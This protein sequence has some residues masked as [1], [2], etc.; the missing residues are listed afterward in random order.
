[1]ASSSFSTVVSFRADLVSRGVDVTVLDKL[2]GFLK[3][4]EANLELENKMS[5]SAF[6]DAALTHHRAF[7]DALQTLVREHA[8]AL[9]KR[10]GENGREV[11]EYGDGDQ[12]PL[13]GSRGYMVIF[14]SREFFIGLHLHPKGYQ[15]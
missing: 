12:R 2:T 13:E 1:M 4:H 14:L 3:C 8:N 9:N 6:G 5:S 11:K 15:M 10:F 7:G